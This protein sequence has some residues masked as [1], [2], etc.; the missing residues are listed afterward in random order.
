MTRRLLS[1]LLVAV[2]AAACGGDDTDAATASEAAGDPAGADAPAPD[3]AFPRTVE[4]AMG[5]TEIPERPERVV[6]LDTGELDSAVALGVTPVGAVRAPVEDGFLE[7]L[8]EQTGKTELV[9]AIDAVNL[10]AVAALRPDLI[11]SSALRHEDLYDELS[12]IAPTVFTEEVG[13]V[14]KE[15]LAVHAE[16]LGREDEAAALLAAY[17]ERTDD[18]ASRLQDARDE[19]PTVSVVR[20]LPGSTRLYQKASF[21]GTVLQDVGLPRPP[22]QDVDDFALEI[23]GE[24]LAEADADVIFTTHYGPADDTT[25]GELTANPIWGTL[26]AVRAGDVHAVSDDHWMLGI[27]IGAANRVLDDLESLLLEA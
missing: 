7:Y 19:L 18:L 17:D 4:H 2:L 1:L 22:A 6:V 8:S 16:A 3:G 13:V 15:N 24:Q 26:G 10:E 23:S 5:S 20:F 27:G 25:Q 14:W 9:G 12:A 11:L 21:I